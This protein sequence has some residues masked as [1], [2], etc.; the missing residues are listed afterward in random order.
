MRQLSIILFIGLLII[1][2]SCKYFRSSGL[3][4]KRART[5]AVL[6]AQEDSIRVAD[7]LQKITDR[8]KAIEN[9]KLD[10]VRKADEIWLSMESRYKYN[11]IVGSFIT[12]EYAKGMTENYRK[13]GY[14]PKIIKIEGS[15][16]ELV[17]IE[18]FN[19]FTKAVSR[20]KRFQ[21][22]IQFEAW[23]YIKK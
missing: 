3:F 23:I 5:L 14:D 8:L 21:D 19:S 16:F 22:T 1:L 7:S 15:K 4:G 6:K 9:A 11:I 18:A 20:L 13:N 2:P 17:S 12:P 10:S